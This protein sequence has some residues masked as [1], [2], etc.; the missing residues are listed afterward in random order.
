M[1][2]FKRTILEHQFDAAGVRAG[3]QERDVVLPAHQLDGL[4]RIGPQ[5][6]NRLGDQFRSAAAFTDGTQQPQQ[7]ARLLARHLGEAQPGFDQTPGVVEAN[8][9]LTQDPVGVFRGGM[10]GR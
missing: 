4:L 10:P 1:R 7:G 2:K 9:A 5:R 3:L 6:V 8:Q